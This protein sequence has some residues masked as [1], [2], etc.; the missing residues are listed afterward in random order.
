MGGPKN[1]P[2]RRSLR[3]LVLD[4]RYQLRFTL[5]MVVLTSLLM[6]VIGWR[7][8]DR[9][10]VATDVA[11][12]HIQGQV[13][14]AVP[15]LSEG[16]PG[17]LPASGEPPAGELA[18]RATKVEVHLD[19]DDDATVPPENAT[20]EQPPKVEPSP[21]PRGEPVRNIEVTL[22]ESPEPNRAV[23]RGDFVAQLV[24]S[25]SCRMHQRA[26]LRQLAQGRKMITWVL[27][28]VGFVLVIG[29]ALYGLKMT[30]RV[31]GPMFKIS[32]YFQKM[33]AN[34]LETPYNLRKGDQLVN[35]YEQF[36]AAHEGI[37]NMERA[38]VE[39]LRDVIAAAEKHDL[40]SAS[41]ELATLIDQMRDLLKRKEDSLG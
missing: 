29:L 27:L 14:P 22:E 10:G 38:D 4:K 40:S 21:A 36:K 24:Q 12:N 41:P 35:F 1:R 16:A 39:Q 2:Y 28:V 18:P 13:C 8:N 31:A 11:A 3:N 7:V 30:H 6:V 32:L 26:D 20:T 34:N 25:Y 33:K 17:A 37:R 15:E 23:V 19:Q 9:A 5:F